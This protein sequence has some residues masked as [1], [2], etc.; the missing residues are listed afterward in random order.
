MTGWILSS[1]SIRPRRADSRATQRIAVKQSYTDSSRR[2]TSFLF[3]RKGIS[4]YGYSG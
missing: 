3:K 1:N 4:S 2:Q